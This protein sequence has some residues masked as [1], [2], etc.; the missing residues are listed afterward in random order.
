AL[1]EFG[2]RGIIAKGFNATFFGNCVRNGIVPI[3]LSDA[4]VQQ[5]AAH[6]ADAPDPAIVVD[7]V[8]CKVLAGHEYPFVIDAQ[9]REMLLNGS[10][11][12]DL[13]MQFQDQID[14]F[15][16]ADRLARPWV[17]LN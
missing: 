9:T 2:I 14:S 11:P 10:D 12:I 1:A 16:Q 5:V 6:A 17:Y 4:E 13:T 3:A 7:L 8:D 15:R